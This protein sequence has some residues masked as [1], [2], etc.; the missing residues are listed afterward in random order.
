MHLPHQSPPHNCSYSSFSRS[1]LDKSTDQKQQ[2]Q[3]P[4]GERPVRI[5][6]ITCATTEKQQTS[7]VSQGEKTF[8][9][10]GAAAEAG[11]GGTGSERPDRAPLAPP[12]SAAGPAGRPPSPLQPHGSKT[13]KI[14]HSISNWS[15][16]RGCPPACGHTQAYMQASASDAPGASRSGDTSAGHVCVG[17]RAV[18]TDLSAV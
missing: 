10:R 15:T 14:P 13:S 17:Q 3:T 8:S 1:N 2:Q 9:P 4:E 18:S 5:C 16:T 11:P 7:S 12:A 6:K